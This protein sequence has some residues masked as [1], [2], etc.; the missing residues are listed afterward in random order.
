MKI[1]LATTF[2]TTQPITLVIHKTTLFSQGRGFY[3]AQVTRNSNQMSH[4]SHP[5][6]LGV[7]EDYYN[8]V[9]GPQKDV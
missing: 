1:P 8:A 7:G 5:V 4:K 6:E 2:S 3:V 9:H